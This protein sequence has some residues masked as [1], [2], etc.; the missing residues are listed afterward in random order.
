MQ[1][2][3]GN[4]LK[5]RILVIQV[6]FTA[7]I[8]VLGAKSVDI[9]IF[10]AEEL[11]QKAE[12]D[13]SRLIRI[14]GE[15]GEILDRNKSKLATSTI[16]I[17]VTA[18]PKKI[19]DPAKAARSL[20]KIL[21]VNRKKLEKTLS[22]KRMFAW[23]ARRISPDQADQIR[24]LKLAGIYFEEDFKRVYP[25]RETAAQVIGFTGSEDTGLEGLEFK[26]NSTLEG[27]AEKIVLRR[28]GNGSILGINKE[29]KAALKGGSVVLTLDKKIQYLSEQT[30]EKTV[31][32][33]HAKS[34]IALVMKP[35]TGELLAIA[36]YPKF[37]PNNFKGIKREFFRNRSITDAFEPGSVIKV[38]TAAAALEK[39]F[40]PKSIFFCENGTYKIGRFTIHDTHPHDWLSINHIIKY[41]SNIGAAKLA[42]TIGDKALYQELKS[43][44]FG[45]KTDVGCPGETAGN[46]PAIKD[47]SRIDAGS[48]SFGQGM[49]VSAV[50][51]ISGVSA[52]ANN[53][54]LMQPMLVKQILSN[55]GEVL[56]TNHPKKL[57]QVVSKKTAGQVKQMMHLVVQEEGTGS[58]AAMDGYAVC[59]KT[60]TAQKAMRNQKGYSKDLYT[61]V[62]AGFAPLENPELAILVVVDEPM[63]QYYGGEVAAPA[64]KTIMTES[65]SYLNVPPET[66]SQMF[67]SVVKENDTGEKN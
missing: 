61:A 19:K 39:G 57:R 54:S 5:K 15:R 55:T 25:H 37:N 22:S 45:K 63:K 14:K 29:K 60:G 16:A 53:G 64:F 4:N 59:G 30:L 49:S 62:F 26:F 43:F 32:A 8:F 44:G 51:L 12:N 42:E 21:D 36:H 34:G 13:Y 28:A 11:A 2:P 10:Q 35:A 31:N 6:L 66:G 23:I 67:A 1:Q 48:I 33:H 18:C 46:L 27:R 47:W 65:L 7:A 52:I 56:K 17:S 20:A 50:Q 40:T 24:Q 58:K 3:S 41:S 38:F 9:Q